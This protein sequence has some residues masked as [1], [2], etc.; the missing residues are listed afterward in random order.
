MKV[1]IRSRKSRVLFASLIFALLIGLSGWTSN[2]AGLGMTPDCGS[3][4]SC[5]AVGCGG[6]NKLCAL[7]LCDYCL[8]EIPLVPCFPGV[9]LCTDW[10]FF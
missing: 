2:N 10:G 5:R 8:D 7:M 3:A 6:G 9:Q 4:Q 1:T